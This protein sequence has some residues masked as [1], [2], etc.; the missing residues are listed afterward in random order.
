MYRVTVCAPRT[1]DDWLTVPAPESVTV[2]PGGEVEQEFHA[3][4]A[5]LRINI[6]GSDG[7]PRSG[8]SVAVRCEGWGGERRTDPEGW[9][10]FDRVPALRLDVS[11]RPKELADWAAWNAFVA[12]HR[13]DRAAL[14]QAD[15]VLG[16]V[17]ARAG[18]TTEVE[19]TLPE[20]AG[21]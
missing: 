18:A 20:S 11:T 15:L 1:F 10:V 9:V 14:A 3:H 13:G 17:D 6:L 21:Y 5:A 4:S 16:H 8:V 7:K 12:V 19:L 2:T